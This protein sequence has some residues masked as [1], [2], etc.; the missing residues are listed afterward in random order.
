MIHQFRIGFPSQFK[1]IA[2]TV[3]DENDV[4]LLFPNS[5]QYLVDEVFY[6]VEI[7]SIAVHPF[8]YT[9]YNF[10]LQTVSV[11]IFIVVRLGLEGQMLLRIRMP[12]TIDGDVV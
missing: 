6:G 4:K 5:G 1:G 3:F 8:V 2:R 9:L 11:N 7:V 12:Y 10:C